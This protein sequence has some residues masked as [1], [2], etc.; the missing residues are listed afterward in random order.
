MEKKI[1]IVDDEVS[2]LELLSYNIKKDGFNSITA[3]NGSQALSLARREHPD[4][5]LLDLM[6]PD[7][8]GL[9]VCR[10]LRHDEQTEQIPV[11][12]VTARTDET[13]IVKGLELGADDYITKPFS[14]KVALARIH[15]VLR[16]SGSVKNNT[17]KPGTINNN[18]SDIITI[19]GLMID[20][21]RFK[22]QINGHPITLSATEFAIL[23][24]LAQN[25]GRV[26]TR[27][28]IIN[29]I[30]GDSY[31]VTD[32]SIDVQILSIRKKL[33]E[34]DPEKSIIETIRGVGYRMCE[35]ANHEY[36]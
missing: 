9:D 8:S 6:L 32:R 7:M 31:P 1:L 29:A 33:G 3:E 13:D 25:P 22:T 36:L 5:I 28:Q 24:Y 16:R 26:F 34:T 15:S 21:A 35:E 30:K 4:L 12:M 20:T 18:T 19:N 27:H 11:I 10:I 2:I 14:P 23:L 17:E